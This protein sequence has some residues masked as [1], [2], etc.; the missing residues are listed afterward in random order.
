MY[1]SAA[2][3]GTL[4]V[5]GNGMVGHRLCRG[6][7]AR[8][9]TER[10]R[11]VVFGEE[12]WPAYDRVHLTDVLT[13]GG[14]GEPLMA[15]R[16]WYERHG[17]ELH[18]G[19]PVVDIDREA[20]FVRSS[21]G[22]A[23][24]YT[25][26]ALA[27]GSAPF[28]PAIEGAMLPGVF[29][30]R[31]LDDIRAI[32]AYAGGCARGIVIGGGLLGLEAARALQSM[33]LDIAVLELAPA[34]MPS[35]LDKAGSAVLERQITAL[36]IAVRTGVEVQHIKDGPGRQRVL[37]LAGGDTMAA[38]IVVIAAGIRPRA[39]LAARC[40]LARGSGGGVTV[41][42]RLATTDPDIFAVGECASHR[43]QV[44]GLVAPGYAMADTLAANL[45]GESLVFTGSRV[46]TRLKL[47]GIHVASVG[48]A[49]NAG[50]AFRYESD[51]VY[52][53]IRVRNGRLAGAVGVGDWPELAELQDAVDAGRRIWPWQ[54]SRFLRAGRVWPPSAARPVGHWPVSAVV[55]QCLGVTRG[56]LSDARAAGCRSLDAAAAR[57]GA[58]TI[59]GSCG[60][61][62]AELV[63]AP[64]MPATVLRGLLAGS[65]IALAVVTAIVLAP[66]VP[67]AQSIDALASLDRLWRDD[68]FRQIS[69]YTTLA[70]CAAAAALTFRKRWTRVKAGSFAGWRLV[71]TAIGVLTLLAIVVHTGFR[72][73]SH[74][75]MALMT[76]FLLLNAVGALAGGVTAGGDR[77]PRVLARARP[78]LVLAHVL[79]LWPLP[80]LL[81]F[82]VLSVYYF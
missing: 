33:G 18:L 24:A 77:G 60:P 5:V 75:N 66:P 80:V 74:L 55:C 65:A 69:G 23:V 50:A 6:L 44:Y 14:D 11:V 27:T 36:G 56:Q 79:A 38:E 3:A 29:V 62:V 34:L 63:G 13:E 68:V 51:G 82:H 12:A 70:M 67:M 26:L 32:A 47:F 8:G 19:D 15:G 4:V 1:V 37:H 25:R 7:V 20:H 30:Y 58:S 72:L 81:T 39:D 43:G 76:C 16:D 42:D 73:G 59:C 35:Q 21:S 57:T 54:I 46:A 45:A 28:V 61:L 71:H 48:E 49:L 52:R 31:T 9:I 78:V 53:L 17:I 41:D 64:M 10:H 22:R 2:D 40:G